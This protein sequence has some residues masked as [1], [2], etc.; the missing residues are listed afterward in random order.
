LLD[1]SVAESELLG[2]SFVASGVVVTGFCDVEFP[3]S[4]FGVKNVKSVH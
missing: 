1:S 4:A 2:V 3:A